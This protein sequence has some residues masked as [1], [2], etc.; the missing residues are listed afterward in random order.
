MSSTDFHAGRGRGVIALITAALLA[1]GCSSSGS[2]SAAGS[3]GVPKTLAEALR[4]VHA[5]DA[6]KTELSWGQYGGAGAA[7]MNQVLA[8]ILGF[9]PLKQ[10]FVLTVGRAPNWVT[11]LYG[12]FDPAAIGAKLQG[13]GYKKTDRGGG[14]T[15]WLIR[16]DHQID[17]N[18]QPEELAETVNTFNVIRVSKDRVVFGGASADMDASLPAQSASLADD[19]VVGELAKCLDKATSGIYDAG[20]EQLAVGENPGGTESICVAAPDD[21]T[22]RQYGDAFTKAVTSGTSQ[23]SLTPWK[24]LLS[25]PKVESLGGK[26]HVVRLTATDVDAAHPRL[27]NALLNMDVLSLIGKPIPAGRTRPGSASPSPSDAASSPTS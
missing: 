16:D 25:N 18:Q 26:A 11:V 14:V 20:T 15:Q 6:T 3:G 17:M 19:P 5:T 24:E 22:A 4:G 8:P 13:L 10:P 1:G 2:A 23:V 12:S 9:D 7:G 27:V 21:A